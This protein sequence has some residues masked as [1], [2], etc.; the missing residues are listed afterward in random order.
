M[1][2]DLAGG[3]RTPRRLRHF[4]NTHTHFGVQSSDVK[5]GASHCPLAPLIQ[6]DFVGAGRHVATVAGRTSTAA[7]RVPLP[8]DARRLRDGWTSTAVAKMARQTSVAEED[9]T[10]EKVNITE[11]PIETC[12]AA[13]PSGASLPRSTHGPDGLRSI[14]IAKREAAGPPLIGSNSSDSGLV[15][16]EALRPTATSKAVSHLAS[17]P[18][19][20]TR[21]A[22]RQRARA[23]NEL[24]AAHG[25][26]RASGSAAADGVGAPSRVVRI[27]R[28]GKVVGSLKISPFPVSSSSPPHAAQGGAKHPPQQPPPPAG[29]TSGPTDADALEQPL[30]CQLTLGTAEGQDAGVATKLPYS[31]KSLSQSPA[32][33]ACP[34]AGEA[35]LLSQCQ[36]PAIVEATA[37]TA[38]ATTTTRR[39]LSED[40]QIAQADGSTWSPLIPSNHRSAISKAATSDD[41]SPAS[42]A[43]EVASWDA[44]TMSRDGAC[45]SPPL[46]NTDDPVPLHQLHHAHQ[47]QLSQQ[48]QPKQRLSPAE[49]TLPSPPP[50]P[51][52]TAQQKKLVSSSR[53][54]SVS[55]PPSSTPATCKASSPHSSSVSSAR[56]SSTAPAVTL[57][58]P[59]RPA[60]GASPTTGVGLPPS[61]RESLLPEILLAIRP[62][63]TKTTAVVSGTVEQ[64]ANGAGG[65]PATSAFKEWARERRDAC[66]PAGIAP[67]LDTTS[68]LSNLGSNIFKTTLKNRKNV[69]PIQGFRGDRV[70]PSAAGMVGTV[71]KATPQAAGYMRGSCAGRAASVVRPSVRARLTCIGVAR[72]RRTPHCCLEAMLK[73]KTPTRSKLR[74]HYLAKTDGRFGSRTTLQRWRGCSCCCQ[75][76]CQEEAISSGSSTDHGRSKI[77]SGDTDARLPSRTVERRKPVEL[78]IPMKPPTCT[79]TNEEDSDRAGSTDPLRKGSSQPTP[80]QKLFTAAETSA[81]NDGTSEEDK[82]YCSS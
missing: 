12:E 69:Q 68:C 3:P 23:A 80:L 50:A 51:A 36:A 20:H 26:L 14:A 76:R 4:K 63:A 65:D 55:A 8:I 31:L 46:H 52:T 62:T 71:V 40:A 13:A 2:F 67:L 32:A 27:S 53:S 45:G 54:A 30:S 58:P 38:A 11:N 15:P 72:T 43:G 18:L 25:R 64:G 17:H 10:S 5:T 70:G 7:T 59:H 44:E 37:A 29:A 74:E 24:Q 81:D 47:I 28:N 75:N 39:Q 48:K 33:S 61:G 35:H 6:F 60:A 42:G 56:S 22:Q 82:Q 1:G 77:C 41:L 21:T 73:N 66:P 9:A 49:S 78:D 34:T 19:S 79:T 57:H 16:V